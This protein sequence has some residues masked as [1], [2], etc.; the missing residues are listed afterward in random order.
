MTNNQF[1]LSS[2]FGTSKPMMADFQ[3]AFGENHFDTNAFGQPQP[4]FCS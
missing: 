1:P 3:N 2:G 4:E